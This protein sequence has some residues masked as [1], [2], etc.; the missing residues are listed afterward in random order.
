MIRRPFGLDSNR[1]AAKEHNAFDGERSQN[2][3]PVA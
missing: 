2:V 3:S 1:L